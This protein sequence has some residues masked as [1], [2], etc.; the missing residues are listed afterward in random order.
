VVVEFRDEGVS[1]SVP[2]EERPE[3]RRLL[4][5][6]GCGLRDAL[7]P[8]LAAREPKVRELPVRVRR[9]LRKAA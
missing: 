3:G 1:G 4:E 6:M 9:R 7:D 8:R 2:F 5:V